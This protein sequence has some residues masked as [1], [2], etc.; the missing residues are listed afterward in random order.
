MKALALRILFTA[1][2]LVGLPTSVLAVPVLWT[3]NGVT[4]TDGGTASGTF[5]Y[6]ADTNTDSAV[7]ITTT[8]GP[9]MTGSTYGFVCVSPCAGPGRYNATSLLALTVPS[10][11]NSLAG[12]REL[13]L[14]FTSSLTNAGGT[15][16]VS[17][18][19]IEFT[20]ADSV[21]SFS[22][23]PSRAVSGGSI[24]G[25]ALAPIVYTVDVPGLLVGTITTDG[26]IGS[27]ARQNI[28]AWNL[29][30]TVASPFGGAPLTFYFNSASPST[31]TEVVCGNDGCGVASAQAL[32]FPIGFLLELG[33][34]TSSSPA[35]ISFSATD[36]HVIAPILQGN[37]GTVVQGPAAINNQPSPDLNQ[38][39]L[40]GSWY[41]PVKS[42]QGF[43]FEIYP[44]TGTGLAFLSWFTFDTV[45]GGEDAQRWYTAQGPVVTGQPNASLTIYQN[46]DGNFNAPPA[47]TA[48]AVGTVNLS[49]FT[50]ASGHISYS[51]SDGTG[52][53]GDIA[54][55]R[56]TQ[57]VTCSATAPYATNADF[58]L[59]GNWF[60]STIPGQGL[61]IEVNP[62]SGYLF[63]AW[64]T[65]EPGGVG[66]GAAGQ[67]WYT[68][69][70]TF[71]AGMRSIPVT[72][73]ET[74]GGIFDTPTPSGQR[75]VTVG[76]GTLAF[77]SCTAATFGYSFSGGT[78]TGLS[79][80]IN[81]SRV[82]PVP[83]GCTS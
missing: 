78:S 34:I 1:I 20:C 31:G 24:I 26:T 48:I 74:T 3:L 41:E 32:A 18:Q 59:S 66:V 82:G 43:E 39:G 53:T 51:F 49:I 58:A 7:N 36:V 55:S 33:L 11:S 62:V 80:T 13:S 9:A 21:C 14:G 52:R 28:I 46:T 27:L 64:Y 60:D 12:V 57:N 75:T 29:A 37:P 61:T 19:A 71:T 79:G 73:Y 38:H 10:S 17:N 44:S 6:D 50:C 40:T 35:Y 30:A 70:A 4:F 45:A 22:Q 65:Y 16:S 15:V 5:V 47:T 42:G 81:L 67:R 69:Q 77:Q 25:V 63:V 54:L 23:T 2:A 8:N 68:A 83:P 56:L 76:S 72:I